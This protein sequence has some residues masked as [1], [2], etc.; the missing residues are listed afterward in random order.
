MYD[1]TAIPLLMTLTPLM[2]PQTPPQTARLMLQ[3]L[4]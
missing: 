3:M 4:Q 1:S 2:A